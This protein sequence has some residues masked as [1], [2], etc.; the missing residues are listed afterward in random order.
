MVFSTQRFSLSDYVDVATFDWSAVDA[1]PFVSA[2]FEQNG[3]DES[4][5]DLPIGA[6]GT[7]LMSPELPQARARCGDLWHRFEQLWDRHRRLT[8]IGPLQRVTVAS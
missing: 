1:L 6:Y 8:P 3:T 5:F 7:D 4:C 2:L